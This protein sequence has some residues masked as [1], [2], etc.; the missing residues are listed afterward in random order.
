MEKY[1]SARNRWVGMAGGER[2]G[3]AQRKPLGFEAGHI[4]AVAPF[5]VRVM[6]SALAAC[7]SAMGGLQQKTKDPRSR[8]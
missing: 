2:H 3:E 1:T 7:C 6:R 5:T 4:V 8:P